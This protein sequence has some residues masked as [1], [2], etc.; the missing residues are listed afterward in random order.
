[1][2]PTPI[3][4]FEGFKIAVEEVTAEVVEIPRELELEVGYGYMT[5]LLQSHGK[6]CNLIV[7]LMGFP[8]SSSGKESTCHAGD[9]NSIL[10]QEDPLEKG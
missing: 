2:I 8:G 1:M 3:D 10:G 4:D 5:E 7:N 6:T 9:P